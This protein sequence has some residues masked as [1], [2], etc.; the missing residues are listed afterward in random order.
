MLG[1]EGNVYTVSFSNGWQKKIFLDKDYVFMAKGQLKFNRYY[2]VLYFGQIS[3]FSLSAL[4]SLAA[5][6]E[7]NLSLL[8]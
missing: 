1:I 4:S 7:V 3:L 5:L 6:T 2:L 8:S